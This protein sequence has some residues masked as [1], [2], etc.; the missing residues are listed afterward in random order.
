MIYKAYSSETV[1]PTPS[2]REQGRASVPRHFVCKRLEV[3]NHLALLRWSG[4]GPASEGQE[5]TE[6]QPVTHTL[7]QLQPI[8][9]VSV[10]HHGCASQTGRVCKCC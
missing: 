10:R 6:T 2:Q 5:A 1:D 7:Q 4:G 8:E 9:R 3:L